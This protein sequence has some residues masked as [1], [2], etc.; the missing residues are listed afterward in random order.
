MSDRV[1]IDDNV[2]E[3]DKIR[4]LRKEKRDLKYELYQLRQRVDE[5]EQTTE[6]DRKVILLLLQISNHLLEYIKVTATHVKQLENKEREEK[7]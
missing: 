3:R 7:K 4:K 2:V 1:T 5:L 6:K